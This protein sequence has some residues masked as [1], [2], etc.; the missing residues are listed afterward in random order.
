M[1]TYAVCVGVAQVAL[2]EFGNMP[3]SPEG[4]AR[5]RRVIALDEEQGARLTRS[6]EYLGKT[7]GVPALRWVR[8]APPFPHKRSVLCYEAPAETCPISTEGGTRR[9]HFV[10]EGGG[11]GARQQHRSVSFDH[12]TLQAM[13]RARGPAAMLQQGGRFSALRIEDLSDTISEAGPSD[14]DRE[15]SDSSPSVASPA[16]RPLPAGAHAGLGAGPET[17]RHAGGSRPVPHGRGAGGGA[18]RV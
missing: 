5:A 14:A 17:A 10:R 18:P 11:G 7:R 6:M 2:D 4:G 12:L 1:S 3:E 16:L 13:A 8:P 9:V 15:L